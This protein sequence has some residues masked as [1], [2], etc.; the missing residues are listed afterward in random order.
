MKIL[1]GMVE[2]EILA[3][4]RSLGS[5]EPCAPATL[6]Y[7]E[8][9]LLRLI[10]A[11]A[12]R[13]IPCLPF[14]FVPNARWFSEAW[15]YS[16]FLPRRRSDRLAEGWTHADGVV[17][18]FDFDP[19]TKTRLSLAP[20]CTQFVVCE[21]K[22]FSPLDSGTT[23]A[24]GFDQ[25]ARSVGCMA[26]S[27]RRTSHPIK[28]YASL[29]FFVVA[30]E[31]QVNS[32]V[33]SSQ[34]TKESILQRLRARVEMY[35]GEP[36]HTSLLQWYEQWALP[37]LDHISLGCITWETVIQRMI[38]ADNDLGH[39]MHSF[40]ELCLTYNRLARSATA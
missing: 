12:K 6:L 14:E 7:N 34:V 38:L 18:H 25:A 31:S 36:E 11:A 22:V 27:L 20:T 5:P 30:P 28:D 39:A 9:W 40:Y 16:A 3:I 29:G 8:G 19:R 37:L 33:F 15:L 10:L 17:G 2:T 26:E 4:L 32:G 35:E 1:T 23:N 13:G 21:A 24:P